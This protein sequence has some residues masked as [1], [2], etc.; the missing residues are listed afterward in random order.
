MRAEGREFYGIVHAFEPLA[1]SAVG[2][3]DVVVIDGDFDFQLHGWTAVYTSDQAKV[4]ILIEDQRLWDV[5]AYVKQLGTGREPRYLTPT[6]L[7]PASASYRVIADDRQTVAAENTVR[8]LSFGQRIYRAPQRTPV[9]YHTEEP[10]TY[11][12]NFTADNGGIGTIAASGILTFG[13]GISSEADFEVTALSIFS[14]HAATLEID[15][16]GT[17]LKWFSEPVH[18]ALLGGTGFGAEA[19]RPFPLT[20]PMH[21]PA[22]GSLNVRCANLDT[23]N[24]NRVQVLFHGKRCKPAGGIPSVHGGR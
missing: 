12:A 15:S 24:A 4:Q 20:V 10:F 6:R 7:V 14:D 8:I 22:R 16:T 23:A 9:L 2:S 18:V 21:I 13:I 17:G 1:A 3:E 19:T 11:V 5:P